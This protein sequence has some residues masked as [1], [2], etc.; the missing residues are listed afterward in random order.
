MTG[1]CAK[2]VVRCTLITKSGE[3]IIGEN[4]CLNPQTVCP[5]LPGEDYTKCVTVCKQI[6]HAE[7][8]AVLLAGPKARGAEAFLEGH[9]Y[10]CQDCQRALT[11]AGVASLTIGRPAQETTRQVTSNIFTIPIEFLKP[12]RRVLGFTL[13]RHSWRPFWKQCAD[14]ESVT[15]EMLKCT[16]CLRER[17]R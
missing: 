9:T 7:Q 3:R 13:C 10:A 14:D 12:P 4:R 6:G 5:R 11:E 1:P 17:S 8:V 15:V 2:T 16:R